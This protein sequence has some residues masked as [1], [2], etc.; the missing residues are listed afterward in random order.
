MRSAAFLDR[1][2]VLIA[3]TGYP[4]RPEQAQVTPGAWAAVRR[5]NAAGLFVAVV[6]NQAGVARGLYDEAQ[7]AAMHLWLRAQ[8]AAAGARLDAFAHCPFHPTEGQGRYRRD[9]PRRKPGPGMIEDLLRF[10]PLRR[11]GSFLV[12][13]RDTDLQAAAA[14]GIPGHRFPGGDLDAFVAG[15]LA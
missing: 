7:V 4:H 10:F 13:D 9:S 3:D 6:T 2:G 14:A 8:A 12:G 15:I 5:L 11:D 1:D